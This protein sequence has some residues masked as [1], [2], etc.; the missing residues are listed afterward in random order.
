[1]QHHQFAPLFVTQYRASSQLSVCVSSSSGCLLSFIILPSHLPAVIT[2]CLSVLFLKTSLMDIFHF[3]HTQTWKVL[4][5][6]FIESFVRHLSR[7]HP[8]PLVH[9]PPL[10]SDSDSAAE[11]KGRALIT[12]S[13][14]CRPAAQ[15][16]GPHYEH[17]D[18]QLRAVM[19]YRAKQTADSSETTLPSLV[20]P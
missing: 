12:Y 6:A 1:M 14:K 13:T 10:H 11:I 20:K 3:L 5:R 15:G 17:R 19:T 2:H 4:T 7:S 16:I 8:C 9:F 18:S